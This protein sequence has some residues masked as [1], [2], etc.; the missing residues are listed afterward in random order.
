MC[1]Q[2]LA[3][4]ERLHIRWECRF[5]DRCGEDGICPSGKSSPRRARLVADAKNKRSIRSSS[6]RHLNEQ[7]FIRSVGNIPPQANCVTMPASAAARYCIPF[8][9]RMRRIERYFRIV[10]K[11]GT[12][13]NAEFPIK[14]DHQFFRARLGNRKIGNVQMG[15]EPCNRI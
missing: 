2:R 10:C 11:K 8:A 4:A 1:G 5:P 7:Q 12:S 13:L 6:K 15:G 14:A 9:K 3:R